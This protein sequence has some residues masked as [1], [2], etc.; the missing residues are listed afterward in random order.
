[1]T[2]KKRV[3]RAWGILD[4]NNVFYYVPSKSELIRPCA[5]FLSQFMAREVMDRSYKKFPKLKRKL[6]ELK[7]TLTPKRKKG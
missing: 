3:V 4:E 1:M 7:I 5:I 6:V 2:K